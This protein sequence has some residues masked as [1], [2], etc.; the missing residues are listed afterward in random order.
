ML[1]RR[2]SDISVRE[3]ANVDLHW[4]TVIASIC[5]IVIE[6]RPRIRNGFR[7]TPAS[8]FYGQIQSSHLPM[9]SLR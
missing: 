8:R 3:L 1:V 9:S 2:V 5:C 4:Q 6:L 7:L